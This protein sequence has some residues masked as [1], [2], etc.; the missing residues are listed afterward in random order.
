MSIRPCYP[1]TWTSSCGGS[2]MDVPLPQL[3]QVCIGTLL[4]STPFRILDC[5]IC[6]STSLICTCS[7]CFCVLGRFF[8][9]NQQ[10]SKSCHLGLAT[11]CMSIT[12]SHGIACTS[13]CSGKSVSGRC[14]QVPCLGFHIAPSAGPH[15]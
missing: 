8:L 4:S 5:T 6:W 1:C 14:S 9:K 12:V 7:S 2:A 11:Y 10:L 3:W 15:L 13:S